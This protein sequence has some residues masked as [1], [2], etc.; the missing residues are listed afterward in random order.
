MWIFI[1][2]AGFFSVV[3]QQGHPDQLVVRARD[4]ADLGRLKKLY[5]PRLGAVEHTPRRDYSARATCSKKAFAEAV[6]AAVD[7]VGYFNFKSESG[8]VLGKFREGVYHDVWAALLRLQQPAEENGA[9][10]QQRR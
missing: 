5:L 2:K 4:A 9:D 3:R 1:A 7:D 6:S 10:E 8:R